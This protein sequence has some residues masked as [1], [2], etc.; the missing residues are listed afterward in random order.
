MLTYISIKNYLTLES[1]EMNFKNGMTCITGETGA[2]KSILIGAINSTLGEATPS[3]LIKNGADKLEVMS[4]FNIKEL[5]TVKKHLE[6]FEWYDG[7]ELVIRRIVSENKTKCF[8]NSHIC[9]VSDLKKIAE[10]LVTFHDQNQQQNLVKPKRQMYMLDHYCNNEEKLHKV[11]TLYQKIKKSKERLFHLKNNFEET[12]AIFQLLNYQVNEIADLDLK[13]NEATELESEVKKLSKANDYLQELGSAKYILDNDENDLLS[14]MRQLSR[15][16][17]NIDDDGKEL[18][19]IREILESA[20]INIKEISPLIDSYADTF[21]VNPERYSEATDRLDAILTIAS[22]HKVHPDKLTVLHKELDERLSKM[23]SEDMD[24]DAIQKEIDTLVELYLEA[25][26]DLRNSRIDGIPK[27]EKEINEELIKLNFNKDTFS[28]NIQPN[29]PQY[30]YDAEDQFEE[31]GI[32]KID[33][34]IQPNSGQDKQLLSKSASGG[35]LSRISLVLELISSRKNAIPTLIFDEVDSGIGGETGVAVG[36]LLKAI[37]L[38]NQ[39][40]VIT[41]LPQVA[42]KASN[43]IVVKKKI[44]NDITHTNI[45]EVIDN[46]RVQEVARMLGGSKEIS[47]ETWTYARKLMGIDK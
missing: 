21:D 35:E 28:I 43:H 14:Q 37:G 7:D 38:N 9:K 12:N 33:F 41:H 16:L 39:L 1:F 29:Y 40:F 27:L 24:L 10:L 25:A 11:K 20:M 42:A 2:G 31:H 32:D 3:S 26:K 17:D 19:E 34:Y 5:T 36:D 8:I 44:R 6:D 4:I 22:K 30:S 18:K 15:H 46:D 45:D 47:K 23:D 13:P